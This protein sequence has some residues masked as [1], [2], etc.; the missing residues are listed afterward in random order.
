MFIPPSAM[1]D[2]MRESQSSNPAAI[3]L[4]AAHLIIPATIAD[5]L[6]GD[7]FNA[8]LVYY[9]KK[10]SLLIAGEQDELFKQLHK[11]KQ[12]LLKAADTKGNRSIALYELLI[13]NSISGIDRTLA[14]EVEKDL[15]VLNVQ[16]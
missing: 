4:R 9:P 10:R 15:K 11:S 13:D 6:F 2:K 12:H 14:Y 3:S 8:Q 16:L 1:Q 7:S 5:G